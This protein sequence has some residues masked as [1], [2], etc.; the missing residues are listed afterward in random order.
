[1][2][3]IPSATTV[4]VV[5]CY[6]EENRLDQQA[7]IDSLG[8]NENLHWLFVDDGSKDRTPIIIESMA[9]QFPDRLFFHQLPKNC[10]KGE[11]V[12]QGLLKALEK[13]ASLVGYYDA[14]LATPMTEV[15]R[16][17]KIFKNQGRK[18]LLGSRVFLLGRNIDRK[19][20]RFWLGR[21]FALVASQ[22]L[23]LKVY[24]T[25][26][27]MKLIANFPTLKTCLDQPFE[28]SW[29]FDVELIQRLL[30][31]GQLEVSDFFEEPLLAWTDVGGSKVKAKA[32]FVA[33]LDLVKIK[34]RSFR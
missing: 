32:F 30:K 9:N 10:G 21:C 29:L 26:C 4:I 13:E 33:L 31:K 25:Q 1:M 11:A 27:G 5:P 23:R 15:F 6:N 3:S 24:D 19:R 7:F 17:L 14:D 18:V 34:L 2:S 8:Q 22:M 20:W 12:R 28:S 16:L